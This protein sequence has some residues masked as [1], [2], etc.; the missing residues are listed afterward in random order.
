LE[1]KPGADVMITM[2]CDFRRKNWRI[3]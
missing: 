3:S 2:F 1:L